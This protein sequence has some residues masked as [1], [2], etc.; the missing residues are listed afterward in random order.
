MNLE[1]LILPLLIAAAILGPW[2]LGVK[3]AQKLP[4]TGV[5]LKSFMSKTLMVGGGI[6]LLLGA[7]FSADSLSAYAT[8]GLI[9]GIAIGMIATLVLAGSVLFFMASKALESYKE[10]PEEAPSTTNSNILDDL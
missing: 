9:L 8:L 6:G 5:F 1:E 2:I 3:K 4:N 10:S 7:Y